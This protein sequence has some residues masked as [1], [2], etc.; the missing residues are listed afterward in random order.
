M[1]YGKRVRAVNPEGYLELKT[2]QVVVDSRR[3]VAADEAA[4]ALVAFAAGKDLFL[5]N[6]NQFQ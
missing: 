5:I 1:G 3:V 6:L 2:R 4:V